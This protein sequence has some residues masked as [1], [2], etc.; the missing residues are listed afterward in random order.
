M[1]L[2]D[3]LVAH[4]AWKMRFATYLLD[5]DGSLTY[6]KVCDETACDLG[7]WEHGEALAAYGNDREYFGLL[8]SHAL[9]HL[10]AAEVVRRANHGEEISEEEWLGP[11]SVYD[12]ASSDVVSRIVHLA[13]RTPV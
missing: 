4:L 6:E 10:A 2:N 7:N 8:T 13:E 1:D 12:R 9:F 3:A 11:G 5:P